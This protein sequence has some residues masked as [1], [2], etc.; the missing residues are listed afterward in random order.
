MIDLS[1][2]TVPELK[3]E[4]KRLAGVVEV[5]ESQRVSILT[6]INKRMN[7]AAAKAAVDKMNPDEV[8]ALRDFLK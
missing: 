4:F 8:E 1:K 3:A 7:S 6:E 2:S 5:A